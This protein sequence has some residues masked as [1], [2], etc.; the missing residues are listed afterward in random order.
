MIKSLPKILLMVIFTIGLFT[1]SSY[2]QM[3][4]PLEPA[5]EGKPFYLG[6]VFGYNRVMHNTNKPAVTIDD[7]NA[8]K[9]PNFENGSANGFF[10]GVSFE[11]ML[12]E[13]TNS[14]SSIIARL[15]YNTFPS[16]FEQQGDDLPTAVG[17]VQ[18]DGTVVPTITTTSINYLND[19]TYETLSLDLLFKFNFINS[20][21]VGVGIVGGPT[22]D[23]ALTATELS[24]MRLVSP[25][26]AQLVRNTTLETDPYN[27]KYSDDLK[28]LKFSEGDIFNSASLRIGFKVGAQVEF[29][30]EQFVVVPN[31][32]YNLALTELSSEHD[33]RVNALQIGVDV[34]FA[35]K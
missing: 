11:Y 8:P 33:W 19:I 6:P 35:I 2:G 12:G 34:R 31:I 18:S 5:K 1:Q 13:A 23:Y 4:N 3:D 25:D 26:N 10:A 32:M 22:F 24:R 16:Y 21:K 29:N 20:G 7:P 17:I 30:F 9:C 15:L 14:K 27:Y 28:E